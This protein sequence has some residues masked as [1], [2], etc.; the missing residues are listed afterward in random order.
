[1]SIVRC[2]SVEQRDWVFFAYNLWFQWTLFVEEPN[3]LK[4]L[5]WQWDKA[6]VSITQ[7]AS[8]SLCF[9]YLYECCNFASCTQVWTVHKTLYIED[10]ILW[11]HLLNLYWAEL[12][13]QTEVVYLL[14][15]CF[16]VGSYFMATYLAGS[17]Y[18]RA[19]LKFH[20]RVCRGPGCFMWTF[21]VVSV[22]AVLGLALSVLLHLRSGHIYERVIED[23]RIERSKRGREVCPFSVFPL[24]TK[25]FCLSSCTHDLMYQAWIPFL[26]E[27]QQ[28]RLMK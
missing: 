4:G 27:S 11:F 15:D 26:F 28:A 6:W 2:D 21:I 1:M 19:A 24:F 18:D 22:F 13:Q 8:T 12:Q 9:Q 7:K 16:L 14:I 23:T 25:N 10:I 20:D 17:L 3:H 5:A